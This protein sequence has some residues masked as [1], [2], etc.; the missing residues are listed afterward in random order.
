[1]DPAVWAVLGAVAGGLLVALVTGGCVLVLRRSSRRRA[2]E[3]HAAREHVAALRARLDELTEELRLARAAAP[4]V[5]PSSELV[6]TTAGEDLP[7]HDPARD[8]SHLPQVPE[9]AVLSVTLGEPLVK[10]A[11]WTYGV[12]RALSPESRNRIAFE[13]RREVKRSRK[14]RRRAARRARMSTAR[15]EETAA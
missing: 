4:A 12:R 11:A 15:A 8:R 5:L 9:G 13:M 14:E 6:I 2:D 1:M 3:L 10:L 7:T